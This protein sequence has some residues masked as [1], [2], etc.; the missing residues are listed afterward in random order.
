MVRSLSQTEQAKRQQQ[1]Q[2]CTLK[3]RMVSAGMTERYTKS[4]QK[5]LDF[6]SEFHYQVASWDDLDEV[7]SEWLEHIFHDGQ[8]KSL[9]SDGL[10]GL[11]Y[12][13]PQSMGR[14]KHAWKL[15]KVWQKL[16]PPRRVLPIS[17]LVVSAFAGV[18]LRLGFVPEAS[19]LLVGFD[20]MLRSG[21][22][23]RL[24]IRDIKFY[25]ARAVLSLGLTKTGKRTNASEMVVVESALA[26][27]C[28][29]NG[30]CSQVPFRVFTL[31]W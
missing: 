28:L 16:E 21:E 30:V 9:A 8:H 4:V 22:L 11:Q 7:V 2:R 23:Y 29:K 24:R 10:A 6:T 27:S 25:D 14:L 3:S 1:R 17:P 18:S 20:T 26:I 19:A 31:A 13:L 15:V 12:H 5:F